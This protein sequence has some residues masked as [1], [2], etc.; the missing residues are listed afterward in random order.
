[1]PTRVYGQFYQQT[2]VTAEQLIC[3][4]HSCWKVFAKDNFAACRN[5]ARKDVGSRWKH[6][7]A[8]SDNGLEVAEL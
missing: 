4:T 1:M 6:A 2:M 5:Y 7:Q 3:E 8:F